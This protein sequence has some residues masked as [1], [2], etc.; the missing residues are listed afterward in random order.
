MRV[1]TP[2]EMALIDRFC[3]E[4]RGI[5]THELMENAG[6]A[7]ARE[8]MRM[9]SE[10]GGNQVAV[11]CGKGNNGGDGLVAARHLIT[12]GFDVGVFVLGG[13]E[14]LEGEPASNLEKLKDANVKFVKDRG[15]IGEFESGQFDMVIDAIF[16][17]GFHGSA[18]G[19]Y[20]EAIRAINQSEK[21]VLSVDIPSGVNGSTGCVEGIAV[22]AS[23]TVTFAVP[24]IG[25]LQYPGAQLAGE[26]VVADIGIPPDLFD[27]LLSSKVFV[28]TEEEAM[29][30]L[31]RREPDTHKW[32]CGSV[33]VIGGSAGM[34]G[35]PYM[36]SRAAQRSGAGMVFVAVPRGIAGI[37]E[38]KT[39]EAIVVEL[40]Q[41]EDQTIS[42]SAI[43]RIVEMLERVNV[44]VLGPG[45]RDTG[46]TCRL[47]RNILRET[48]KPIVLD[49]D[50]LN[51]I[52]KNPELLKEREAPT[53]ITPHPG[54]MARLLGTDS[55]QVQSDRVLAARESAKRFGVI[56]VLKGA[57][58]VIA[59]PGGEV[60]INLTGNPGMATAGMGDVLSGMVA[61]LLAQGLDPFGAAVCGVYFHGY[62]GDLVAQMDAMVGMVA[63]DVIRYL[64]L[65]M[66]GGREQEIRKISFES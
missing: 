49:A 19:I 29:G 45:M 54:E 4:K 38:T 57:G 56:T 27:E 2:D 63:G 53:V 46:N 18:S 62:A 64:P 39:T 41:A 51:A 35:A 52:A 9:L 10:I 59:E 1:V 33:L 44:V 32:K 66:R 58:T 42:T 55:R 34:S 43:P 60:R 50:G 26:I 65:A 40:D 8:A 24:K 6:G 37:I 28:T 11:W 14:D 25:L 20:A 7:V 48:K 61:S 15:G 3:I 47:T 22:R 12:G 23:R 31:P 36:C 5:P 30:L 16:G 13:K 21:A 17:T